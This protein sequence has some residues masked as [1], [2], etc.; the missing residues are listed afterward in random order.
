[1]TEARLDRCV[2]CPTA[3]EDLGLLRR[4]M[5]KDEAHY[6]KRKEKARTSL[7]RASATVVIIEHTAQ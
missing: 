3:G 7:P 2:H 4:R 5:E 6:D 1:M